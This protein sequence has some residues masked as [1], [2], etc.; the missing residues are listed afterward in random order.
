M[1]SNKTAQTKIKN[2]LPSFQDTEDD[3]EIAVS[4]YRSG[5]ALPIPRKLSTGTVPRRKLSAPAAP[6]IPLPNIRTRKVSCPAP[7]PSTFKGPDKNYSSHC[8]PIVELQLLKAQLEVITQLAEETLLELGSDLKPS[9]CKARLE[10]EPSTPQLYPKY[11]KVK[12]LTDKLKTET[13]VPDVK[14]E[15]KR[16]SMKEKWGISL[17]YNLLDSR[18]KIAVSKVSM[19]SPAAKAGLT[20]GCVILVINDWQ[21]EAMDQPQVAVGILLAAGFSVNLAWKNDKDEISAWTDLDS[22]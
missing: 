3:V 21:I 15:L 11:N 4:C 6:G 13:G 2:G 5:G 17:K 16:G 9:H 12:I 19:F 22:F 7:T 14:K 20:P 18:L 10:K 8:K 1:S